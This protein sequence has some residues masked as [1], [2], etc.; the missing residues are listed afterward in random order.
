MD[1]QK[2]RLFVHLSVCPSIRLTVYLLCLPEASILQGERTAML[3]SNL[4]GGVKIRDQPI[5]TRNLV[6]WLSGKS[7]ILL[8]P[9]VTC[10][11]FR[12]WRPSVRPLCEVWH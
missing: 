2:T 7:S 5:N 11:K 6:S 10:T 12:P 8:P 9:D 3:H 4:R 1:R